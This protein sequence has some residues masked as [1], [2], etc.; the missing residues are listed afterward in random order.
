M[1]EKQKLVLEIASKLLASLTSQI[2]SMEL[3]EKN[4]DKLGD[5][6]IREANKLY[7]KVEEGT[8]VEFD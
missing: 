5:I 6:C 3:H 4:F 1:T 7:S 8:D 2:H